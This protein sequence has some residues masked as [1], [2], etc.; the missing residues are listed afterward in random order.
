MRYTTGF[1]GLI[2][3]DAV[4]VALVAVLLSGCVTMPSNYHDRTGDFV[5]NIGSAADSRLT[6]PAVAGTTALGNAP[7]TGVG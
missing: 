3:R 7:A 6:A 4:L 2:D 5:M 1:A